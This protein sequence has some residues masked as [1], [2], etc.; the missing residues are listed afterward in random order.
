MAVHEFVH[1]CS[2]QL[3][4]VPLETPLADRLNYIEPIPVE[5]MYRYE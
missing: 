5:G 2:I 4:S 1:T 3:L